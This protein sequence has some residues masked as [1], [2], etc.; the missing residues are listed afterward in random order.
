MQNI[1]ICSCKRCEILK[2]ADIENRMTRI[3]AI[4]SEISFDYA[5][6][7][8]FNYE[9]WLNLNFV[10]GDLNDYIKRIKSINCQT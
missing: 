7:A 5:F 3:L 10:V 6:G 4:M 2:N 1:N 8:K 9:E